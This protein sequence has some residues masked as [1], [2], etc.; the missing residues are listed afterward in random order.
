MG[1]PR[2][3]VMYGAVLGF[4]LI[5]ANGSGLAMRTPRLYRGAAVFASF[6]ACGIGRRGGVWRWRWRAPTALYG[7]RQVLHVVPAHTSR[8]G[9]QVSDSAILVRRLL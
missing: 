1:L 7:V 6:R 5:L 4:E 3:N 9:Y 8:L 2:T